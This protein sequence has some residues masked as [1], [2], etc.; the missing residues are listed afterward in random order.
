MTERWRRSRRAVLAAGAV[1]LA[2]C[3]STHTERENDGTPA[4]VDPQ[5]VLTDLDTP[6]DVA[7]DADG[8]AYLSERGGRISRV[9]NGER[10]TLFS[11]D[12]VTES[13]EGGSLGL[14]IHPEGGRLYSYH[15][16][17]DENRV[18]AYDL[19]AIDPE[20]TATPILTGIP[21]ARIHNGG[22]I[23]FGP[24]GDLWVLAGDASTPDLAQDPGS[25]AG[26][27]LRMTPAGEPAD[28]NPGFEE[29]RNYTIGHRNPQGIDWLPDGTPLITEHGPSARDEINRLV[30]GE[31]YGWPD[32]RDGGGYP[33]TAYA[34]PLV[35]TGPDETWAP[36]GAT[37]YAGGEVLEWSGRLLVGGLRSRRLLA[38]GLFG[39]GEELPQEGTRYDADWLDDAYTAVATRTLTGELGR[40]RHVQRGPGGALYAI[41]SNRDGRATGRFPREGDDVLVRLAPS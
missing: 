39:P 21:A 9:E 41:T 2:G 20:G 17:G 7:F 8:V 32:A 5:R 13:G 4:P 37:W 28:A 22:R 29:P 31:N 40:I 15:T 36:S 10:T 1:S 6:W 12:A 16:A 26:S 33:G 14:A 27:V 11:P 25:P 18:M 3:L 38:V 19:A 34:Q 30:G 24:G 23:D 35:N